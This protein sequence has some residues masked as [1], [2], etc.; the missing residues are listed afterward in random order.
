[1]RHSQNDVL[2]YVKSIT[3]VLIPF[4]LLGSLHYLFVCFPRLLKDEEKVLELNHLNFDYLGVIVGF[5]ALLVT[6][7]VGWNIYSTIKAKE[8]LRVTK[9]E[10]EKNFAYRMQKFDDCCEKRGKEIEEL[11]KEQADNKEAIFNENADRNQYFEARMKFSQGLH[12]LLIADL[13]HSIEPGCLLNSQL[14]DERRPTIVL[15]FQYSIAYRNFAE[16]LLFYL[17]TNG[18]KS[19]IDACLSNMEVCLDQIDERKGLEYFDTTVY[20]KC[21]TIYDEIFKLEGSPIFEAIRPKLYELHAKRKSLDIMDISKVSDVVYVSG[22]EADELIRRVRAAIQERTAEEKSLNEKAA[23]STEENRCQST[24]PKMNNDK[25][26]R[27]K[28]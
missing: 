15:K 4:C 26:K 3:W 25:K 20:S 27:K 17:R 11:R 1:M 13:G 23:P 16:A 5:F 14:N 18:E 24:S 12:Y 8:E 22:D 7:L 9:D 2:L 10:I 28:K 19:A 6:L 21:N